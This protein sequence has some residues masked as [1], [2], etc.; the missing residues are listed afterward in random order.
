MILSLLLL[1][2]YYG[3]YCAH[4]AH[5]LPIDKNNKESDEA[6]FVI[7]RRAHHVLYNEMDVIR[8]KYVALSATKEM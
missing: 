5:S 7:Q 8:G 4:G 2:I 6:R 3:G 1:Y